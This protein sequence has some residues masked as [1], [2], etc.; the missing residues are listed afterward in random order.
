MNKG[1]G[2]VRIV[3]MLTIGVLV[4]AIVLVGAVYNRTFVREL[5]V[6]S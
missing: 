3:G 2:S 5:P 6:T 4:A 1:W